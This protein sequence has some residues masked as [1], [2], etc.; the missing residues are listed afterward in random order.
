M[1]KLPYQITI[2][3]VVFSLLVAPVAPAFAQEGTPEAPSTAITET[4]TPTATPGSETP[5]VEGTASPTLVPA[6]PVSTETPT[7]LVT[8]TPTAVPS[9]QVVELQPALTL[10]TD[11]EFLT[12]AD[13][14]NLI[15]SLENVSLETKALV[16]EIALPEGF[17][18]DKKSDTFNKDTNTLSIPVTTLEGSIALKVKNVS[19]DSVFS[20]RLIS[21]Q[22]VLAFS[23]VVLPLFEDIEVG[24][25]GGKIDIRKGKV[26]VTF[27]QDALNE[28]VVINAGFP[29][30]DALPENFSSSVFELRAFSRNGRAEIKH[31]E[32]PLTIEVDYSDLILTEEQE[33]ELYLYWYNPETGDWNALESSR[34][35][36]TKTLT[37]ETDHFTVFDVGVNEWNSTNLPTIDSFQVSEFTGAASFSLPLAVPAGMGGFQPDLT[38][39]YNS[40]VVDQA[41]TKAQASWV[42]M[43]WSL[44]G[45]GTIIQDFPGFT[46]NVN[47]ISTKIMVEELYGAYHMEDERFWKIEAL[48]SGNSTYWKLW[49]KQ[50]NQYTFT[51]IVNP[52]SLTTS[53]YQWNLTQVSNPFGRIMTY[54]YATES[55]T[56][57][58]ESRVTAAYVSSIVYPGQRYQVRFAR[59]ARTDY[60]AAWVTDAAWHVFERSR[61]KTVFMEQDADGNGSFETVIRRY[62]FAYAAPTDGDIIWPGVTYSAGGKALTLR[63]VQEFSGSGAS[64]PAHT[65][66]YD[67]LHLTSANNG[68]GGG[69]AFTYDELPWV[70]NNTPMSYQKSVRGCEGT[71]LVWGWY[72]IGSPTL[73]CAGGWLNVTN[74]AAANYAYTN[75]PLLP[76]NNILRPG[77]VYQYSYNA[78][79]V[80]AGATYQTGLYT[81]SGDAD[82]IQLAASSSSTIYLTKRAA[83]LELYFKAIT[84][85]SKF[86]TI[87]ASLM[88]SF[89]RVKTKT[90]TD[91]LAIG[92]YTPHSYTSTYEYTTP[93]AMINNEGLQFRGH[94]KVK[95]TNPDSTYTETTYF[96]G[97]YDKGRMDVSC[98][99]E[100]NGEKISCTDNDYVIVPLPEVDASNVLD[101]AWVYQSAQ[102]NQVYDAN[103]VLVGGTK[104]VYTYESTYGNP[105]RTDEYDNPTGSGTP[106]RVTTTSYYPN[107]TT[108]LVSLPARQ[109]VTANGTLLSEMIY[110]YNGATN[111]TTPPTANKLTR[112]HALV[113]PGQYRQTDYGYDVYGNQTSATTYTGFTVTNGSGTPTGAQTSSTVYDLTYRTY[114]VSVT[115]AAGQTTTLTYDYKLGV[116]LTQTDPNNAVTKVDY[117]VFG[118]VTGVHKPDLLTS[119]YETDASI[120]MSYTDSFPFTTTIT[121][122]D[123]GYQIVKKYDGMGRIFET[124]AAGVITNTLYDSPTVTRQSTP[125]TSSETAYYTTTMVSPSSRTT[126]TTAPDGTVTSRVSNGFTTTVTDALGH[127]T[128]STSDAW[129][130]ATLVTPPTGPVV[131]YAYDPLGNLLQV[132][133]GTP[134]MPVTHINNPSTAGLVAWWSMDETSGTRNDSHVNALHLSDNNTV[135][136]QT[137]KN[138]DAA[139]LEKDTLEYFSRSSSSVL[140]MSVSDIYVSAWIKAEDTIANNAVILSKRNSTTTEAEYLLRITPSKK[141]E[142]VV[143][144]TA[145]G[146]T[147]ATT[148]MTITEGQWYFVEGWTDKANK[149][150]YVNINNDAPVGVTWPANENRN[151]TGPAEF[152]IGARNNNG[153][154]DYWDGLIDEVT[155]Y[156]RKLSAGER[157]WLYNNGVGRTYAE[158]VPVNPTTSGLA[159]WWSM[160]EV[161]GTRNDSHGTNHLTDNNLVP[162]ASG[163][164]GNSAAFVTAGLE[165]LS[166]ADNASLSAGNIDFTISA[167]VY[168]D[169]VASTM[170]IVNKGDKADMNARDFTLFLDQATS[171]L[172]FRVGNGTTNGVVLSAAAIPTGQW[173]SVV[174][175]HDSVHDTLNIQVNDGSV[176][177][178]SYTGGAMDT[179]LPMS[180]GAFADNTYGLS[181]RVDE[182]AVYR[183]VL[184]GPE[185]SWLYSNGSGRAYSELTAVPPSIPITTT[186]TYNSAGQKLTMDDPDMGDWSYTYDALGNLKTQTDAMQCV[187]TM[188]YDSLNRLTNKY[189]AEFNCGASVNVTYNYDAGTNGIGRRTS[190]T[191]SGGITDSWTYDKRGRLLMATNQGLE[192]EYEYNNADMLIT[193]EYPDNEVVTYGYDSRML[194]TS[195]AGTDTYV[196]S[197]T[198]D[199]AGRVDQRVLGNS[200]T[201]NFDYY[202]WDATLSTVGQ[203]GRLQSLLTG[204]LQDINYQYDAVGN[205]KTFTDDIAGETSTYGYDS[206][207][208]L[209]SWTLGGTTETYGYNATTGNLETKAGTTL[210]Y[211]DTAHEHAATSAGGNTYTYDANG[212]QITRVIGADTFNL[213]YDAENRLVKVIKNS[214]TIATFVYDGDGK[215][216]R[217]TENGTL[218]KFIGGHYQVTG[219]EITKYYFAGASRIAMRKY[220]APIEMKVEYLLGDHLGSTSITTD[221]TGAKVSEMRYKPWGEVRY[222]WTSSTSIPLDYSLA[223]YTFTGQYSYMDDP[224]TSGA[225]EGFG[226]MFYNARMYDPILG[227]FTSADSIIPTSQGVQAYDRYAY[228][229]NNPV[230]YDDP[231]GHGV[232]CG[233]GMSCGGDDSNCTDCGSDEDSTPTNTP[234][235]DGSEDD[236]AASLKDAS[237]GAGLNMP[238]AIDGCSVFS[239]GGFYCEIDLSYGEYE[240]YRTDIFRTGV[241]ITVTTA[242]VSLLIG[243]VA[244]SGGIPLAIVGV[245]A[246]GVLAYGAYNSDKQLATVYDELKATQNPSNPS[247]LKIGKAPGS[248]ELVIGPTGESIPLDSS[249][250]SILVDILQSQ[251]SL[252]RNQIFK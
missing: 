207:D 218:T 63:S 122:W 66:Y 96:Q 28:D 74:G 178:V 174:A 11:P 212:N 151:G 26:K 165:S 190:M 93:T 164:K 228:V 33:K 114:P 58:G 44:D 202:A 219:S 102:I 241:A 108:W 68:Y 48:G 47:G 39:A 237:K 8:E 134:S 238:T 223:D 186:L 110:Y 144:N 170:I 221:S 196:S 140:Q 29:S 245:I 9:T 34:D 41:T 56:V 79:P 233:I 52:Y 105:I 98:T 116:P 133:R 117:D 126:T 32:K 49:D 239:E 154:A 141:V 203:G 76:E 150:A 37:A 14:V 42:G 55:K 247:V 157:T 1:K 106:Y 184:S 204:S 90:V 171:K 147:V 95:V 205:I 206:L 225:T 80:T 229:S 77:G 177:T 36:K 131:N 173:H 25:N 217:A 111:Y 59:E 43:G 82:D 167:N 2:F 38:L 156:K 169:S 84:G 187:L 188:N 113:N 252:T 166:I 67:N 181:G 30:G 87:G 4:E 138:G 60:T 75:H 12:Q 161:S 16:L 148:T 234:T 251:S 175:W 23:S 50:G 162:S 72:G 248:N 17:Q 70:Y 115:N 232:D 198:Y 197:T 91:G 35:P 118:R 94:A 246:I 189:S 139:D 73:A 130:R 183:R 149:T 127:S 64:L 159:A 153:I 213:S 123:T 180:V 20:A 168:F 61:L 214:T 230:R 3:F 194:L 250:G 201:Q 53:P 179:A 27:P 65:F 89:Y 13:T 119:S 71:M 85:T 208:R 191:T 6:T 222:S 112:T 83:S 158:V 160:N 215:R 137:G 124:N 236:D 176:S 46:L 120:R 231:S 199:S 99:H 103:G 100:S 10:R 163:L 216:V 227:R 243:I 242:L 69:V 152:L 107:S 209:T 200:L 193:M 128:I 5:V 40:Q 220:D 88:P 78:A 235:D 31:F 155:L 195:V 192:T 21:E 109:A 51:N 172:A 142:F 18:E 182:V 249:A 129:G 240:Y 185:R 62:E 211:A 92:T 15:W 143:W 135:T 97:P 7:P 121:Q 244:F 145:G 226:L 19:E 54:N 24:K 136:S 22:E 86:Y 125:H 210:T 104:N 81:R 101:H 45:G 224:S 57:S 146:Y 132:T